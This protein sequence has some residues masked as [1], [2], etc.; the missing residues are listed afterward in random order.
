MKV[1]HPR[2]RLRMVSKYASGSL[3]RGA[4]HS[5]QG[6]QSSLKK[7]HQHGISTLLCIPVLRF[8]MPFFFSYAFLSPNCLLT[9]NSNSHL[10]EVFW[11]FSSGSDFFLH[12]NPAITDAHFPP[13]PLSFGSYFPVFKS[14]LLDW[15]LFEGSYHAWCLLVSPSTWPGAPH[16][17]VWDK[18]WLTDK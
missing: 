16:M 12:Q 13:L 1:R 10:S 9:L 17:I 3:F 8:G 15:N 18:W 6:R 7:P 14:Y 11:L 4:W 2:L 5:K